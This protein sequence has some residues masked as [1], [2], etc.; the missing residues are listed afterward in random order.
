[1]S[2]DTTG[3]KIVLDVAEENDI[4]G[5]L[6]ML[7]SRPR[8]AIGDRTG[9]HRALVLD[10]DD[11]LLLFQETARRGA[12]YAGGDEQMLRKADNLLQ[13][14]VSR[15]VNEEMEEKLPP[16]QRIADWIAWF[17]GSMQFLILNGFGSWSG[18]RSTRCRRAFRSSTRFRS[19]C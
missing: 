7:D 13:T 16:L 11:L 3:H 14:R 17:S 1:M 9:R 10:R 8:S 4:F 15:N 6:S 18:S 19:D 2:K 5:E 12:E